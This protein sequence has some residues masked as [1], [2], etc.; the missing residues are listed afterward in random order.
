MHARKALLDGLKPAQNLTV[1]P[2]DHDK[3]FRLKQDFPSLSIH[4]NGGIKDI[5]QGYRMIMENRLQ[6][7]MV[8]RLAI[9]N[10]YELTKI[11]DVEEP[12]L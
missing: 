6:G 7:F 12:I 10:P 1:P 5:R 2:L 9:E 8:G 3:V 11:D 4:L